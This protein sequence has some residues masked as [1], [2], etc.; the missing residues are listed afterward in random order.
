VSTNP[1]YNDK[2]ISDPS[3][4]R[5]G[6]DPFAK[7]L[8]TSLEKMKAPEGTV[9]ALMAACKGAPLGWLIDFSES[10]YRDY[11]PREGKSPSP[12]EKCLV[13][14]AD[15]DLLRKRELKAVQLA[16]KSGTLIDHRELPYLLFRWRDLAGRD[17]AAVKKWTKA[18]LKK[19]D[20]VVKIAKAFTSYS[21]SQGMGFAGLGDRVSKRNTR[22]SV[23]SLDLIMDSAEFRR[24]IEKLAAKKT[25]LAPTDAE[26][27]RI[28]LEAWRKRDKDP[29]A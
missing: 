11:H 17:G 21:W 14:S 29:H 27:V 12:E 25:P 8:A 10:A 5:F 18:Q 15:A 7:A 19:D 26:T 24:R 13:L 4:D 6:I 3:E 2:P 28:F 1:S 20:A 9:V 16:V 23:D 22:A